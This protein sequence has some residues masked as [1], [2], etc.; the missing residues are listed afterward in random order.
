MFAFLFDIS[1]IYDAGVVGLRMVMPLFAIIIVYQCYAAMRRRRRPEKPLVSLYNPRSGGMIP[2]V[3]WENSIGRS[4]SSDIVINDLSVSR[5]HCVLLRRSAGWFVSDVGSVTGTYVN[6]VPIHGRAQVLIDD[7]ITIGSTEYRLKR[8]DDFNSP[9]R[10]SRFFSKV[11]DKPAIQAWKLMFMITL[12][13]LFMAVEAMFWNDG[14]NVYS[15]LVLFGAMAVVE[16]GFFSVSY[17]ALRRV[18]FELEALG[19]FLTGIGVMMLIRQVER[20]AYVQLIAM[21]I[22]IALYCVIVKFI[23]DPDRVQKIR[24]PMMIISCVML[25]STIVLGKATNGAANWVYIGSISFQPS[26]FVKTIFIFVGASP[27][28]KLQTKRNLI[29][30][31]IYSAVCVALLALMSDFGTALIFFVTFLLVVFMRSGDI[32]TVL[33]PIGAVIAAFFSMRFLA[34]KISFIG[35]RFNY[36]LNRFKAYRHVWDYADVS[37]GYQQ[38]RVLTYIASGG[39]FGVGIGNGYFKQYFA[40]ESDLVFALVAEEMGVIV[41]IVLA[42]SVALL[43][44]YARAITTRARSTFYSISACCAAGLLVVQLSLNVFGATDILP[45]TGV[46]FPFISAGGSSV[47]SCWGLLAFIKAADERTYSIK[48]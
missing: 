31:T 17:F 40:S 42:L 45:L 44:L 6:G 28:D 10:S 15:P 12:F 43:M 9:L 7:I 11:S 20:S 37:A 46:T 4:K 13:H 5:N 1:V 16:W 35:D 24:I 23:E 3:F 32:K 19:L 26:E 47:I 30:F 36:V 22:G 48:R 8:G 25:A 18:N 27:L 34:E 38:V 29:E 39:L 21:G 41:A 33:I 14:T 2:V